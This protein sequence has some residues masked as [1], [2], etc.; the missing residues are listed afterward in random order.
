VPSEYFYVLTYFSF[1]FIIPAF[2]EKSMFVRTKSSKNSP[3]KSVQVVENQR[4]PIS[5]RVQQ[6]ILQYIGIA[7]NDDEL[8]KLKCLGEEA[9]VRLQSENI[10]QQISLFDPPSDQDIAENLEQK[11]LGRRPKKT[12]EEVL[13][14]DQVTLN[15]VTEEA[16]IIDGIHEVAGSLYDKL[17]YD[18]TLDNQKYNEILKD[19]VL[20][21][22]SDPSSKLATSK[23]LSRYYMKNHEIDTIYRVMDDLF[24][25]IER[26][27]SITFQSTLSLIP[28]KVNL[29]LFDVTTLYLESTH[30]DSLRKFGYSK[31]FRFNTT[32]V[33]L[34]LAS[35]EE[36]LPIGYELF[37]G[38]KAEVSTLIESIDKWK[39]IFEINDVCFIGDRAM[40]SE[41]NLLAL[42]K[43]D[44]R[45]IV[46]A[47]LKSLPKPMQTKILKHSS[48]AL[49]SVLEENKKGFNWIKEFT[50][51]SSDLDELKNNTVNKSAKELKSDV[52]KIINY[53]ERKEVNKE[54]R[55]VISYSGKRAYRDS[56]KRA[57]LIEK[58][59]K[60]L[61]ATSNTAKLGTNAGVK[62]YTSQ[63]GVSKTFID[64][65]K[66]NKEEQ[67]DG[68]HGVIT[69]IK[70]TSM[71]LEEI[72]NRYCRLVKIEDCFRVNKH[73]LKMR[74]IYH[75]KPERIRAHVALCYMAFSVLR[76]LEYRT[77]ILQK[78]S[79]E[80][81][82]EELNSVQSSIYIHK[83][84]QD[85]Y[86]VPGAF[87]VEAR[88]IYKALEIKRNENA[89]PIL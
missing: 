6:R 4:D 56:E 59:E 48:S 78:I 2:R 31:D 20:A 8:E 43:R 28:G 11:K 23:K 27:Q 54:R 74:P 66:I 57:L 22:I 47:K 34:A 88:K 13:P 52:K 51:E 71:S 44:Y 33:V 82:I 50:Y 12:L 26:V 83:K 65:D 40:F 32:Q 38:N 14:V 84:T 69:N 89:Y 75:H 37:E 68:L 60:K 62:K 85:R 77:K 16:R 73:T 21:R 7:F 64:K 70:D 10:R 41:D 5:G 46:A 15:D 3:R 45:Y 61:K 24:K 79:V 29:I 87:S 58:T 19:L 35:T 86:C 18:K 55:F 39:K 72:R 53:E 81:I 76:Q 49:E 42:E 63:K 30:V 17:G 1:S 36:G 67:W 25:N 80:S 9:M